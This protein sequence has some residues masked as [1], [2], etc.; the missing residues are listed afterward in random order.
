MAPREVKR[1]KIEYVARELDK[2]YHKKITFMN[3][4][5]SHDHKEVEVRAT[6]ID[7]HQV[8]FHSV[9]YKVTLD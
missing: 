5:N 7:S 8:L 4:M 1:L 9:F 6:N 2:N 3:V